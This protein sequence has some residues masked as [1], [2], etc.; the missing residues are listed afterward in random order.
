MAVDGAAEVLA[1]IE[2]ARIVPVVTL[3]DAADA[4]LLTEA[5][6]GGGLPVVEI[7]LRTA[8]GLDALG[9]AA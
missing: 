3:E 7:T 4:V 5:L 8:A 9:A 1:A 6:V 2:A